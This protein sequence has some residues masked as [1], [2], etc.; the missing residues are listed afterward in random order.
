MSDKWSKYKRILDRED[1]EFSKAMEEKVSTLLFSKFSYNHII[2]AGVDIITQSQLDFEIFKHCIALSHRF[3]K[4]CEFSFYSR[5]W[6]Q[7]SLDMRWCCACMK[8]KQGPDQKRYAMFVFGKTW[9]L[10]K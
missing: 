10:V 6:I 2:L 8:E 5:D 3:Y 7:I 4:T 9:S 1:E